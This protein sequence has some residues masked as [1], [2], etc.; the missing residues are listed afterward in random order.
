M[1][2]LIIGQNGH[3]S[4]KH[5]PKEPYFFM[6]YAFSQNEYPFD[7]CGHFNQVIF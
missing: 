6:T 3:F 5:Q 7:Q 1:Y 4:Q 2:D